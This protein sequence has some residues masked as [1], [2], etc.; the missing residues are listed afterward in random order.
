VIADA[1]GGSARSFGSSIGTFAFPMISFTVVAATLY[2]LD[3]KPEL[4]PG[5]RNPALK[6]PA[7]CTA[8]PGPPKTAVTEKA[9]AGGRPAEQEPG[10]GE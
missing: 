2:V 10:A 7:I 3:T 1:A 8:V 5:Q 4:A 6:R 9:V